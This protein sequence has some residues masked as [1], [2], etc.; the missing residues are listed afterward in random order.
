MKTSSTVCQHGLRELELHREQK[1]ISGSLIRSPSHKQR[2]AALKNISHELEKKNPVLLST[3]SEASNCLL[4]QRFCSLHKAS[5]EQFQAL[6]AMAKAG[7]MK[8]YLHHYVVAAAMIF[9]EIISR[10]TTAFTFAMHADNVS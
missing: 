9:S 6:C 8:V 2:K 5:L 1:T 4:K 10:I 7:R 3:V